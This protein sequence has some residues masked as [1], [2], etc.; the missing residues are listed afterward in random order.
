MRTLL[1]INGPVL[2]QNKIGSRKVWKRGLQ[3]QVF[4]PLSHLL[5]ENPFL[6]PESSYHWNAEYKFV[7]NQKNIFWEN[8]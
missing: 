1:T 4:L 2:C 5:S 3:F 8:Q 7:L 6:A